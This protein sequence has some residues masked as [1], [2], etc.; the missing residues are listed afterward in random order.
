[1]MNRGQGQGRGIDVSANNLGPLSEPM[2][3]YYPRSVY[4]PLETACYK[5]NK[6]RD[7]TRTLIQR[8]AQ[9]VLFST[10]D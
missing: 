2:A 1:M 6:Y 7:N 9:I 10:C 8:L 4:W 3:M 5:Y